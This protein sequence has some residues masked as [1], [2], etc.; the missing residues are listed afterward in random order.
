MHTVLKALNI[1]DQRS[2]PY[3]QEIVKPFGTIDS[4]INWCKSEMQG[5]WRWQ[6]I[7]ISSDIRPGRYIFYFDSERDLCAFTLKWT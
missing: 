7:E 2:F 6:L 4:V 1:R 5:E 3:T